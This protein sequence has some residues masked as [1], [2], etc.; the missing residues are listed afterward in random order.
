MFCR[1]FIISPA[2]NKVLVALLRSAQF[3]QTVPSEVRLLVKH[4]FFKGT[5]IPPY[6][7]DFVMNK[8]G[9][10]NR[11]IGGPRNKGASPIHSH[12]ILLILI[13]NGNKSL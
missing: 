10:K 8:S 3:E 6:F 1:D 9:L 2:S 4:Y 11:E 5:V 13:L 12:D 7:A